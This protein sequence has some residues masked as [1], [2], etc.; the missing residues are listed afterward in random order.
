MVRLELS[1]RAVLLVA[2]IVISVWVFST[3][4]TIVVIVATSFIFM[5]ALLPFVEWAVAH[6][7]PRVAAVVFILVVI[8]AILAGL[9]AL[10]VPAGIDEF[11][12]LKDNLPDDA[13]RLEDF[14]DDFGIEVELEERARNIDWNRVV[15]GESAI[16][17]GQRALSVLVAVITIFSMTAYLLADTPRMRRFLY[18]FVEP[19]H[20]PEVERWLGALRKVVGGYIRG[21]V[22]TSA[23]ITAFT[24]VVLTLA[25]VPNAIAFAVLAGFVDIIPVIGATIAVVLPTIAAFEE[26]PTQAAIVLIALMAY[27]QFEDRILSP[28]VYG[29][30]LNLPPVIVLIAVLL[31]GAM[32]GIAGVLLA[33]PAAAVARVGLDYYLEKRNL[34]I[35]TT[36]AADEVVSPD[37]T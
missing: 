36:S 23:I 1:Y 28:R 20:E 24:F 6:R 5:A 35:A 7:V 19:G 21:Q 16:D 26:S 13:R 12:D 11:R 33:L 32:F 14:L 9:A 31:G 18:Q 2:A 15:S 25:G 27:Q 3:I 4:W 17:Y 29:A 34:A 37:K 10:V 8:V 30:T 22:I